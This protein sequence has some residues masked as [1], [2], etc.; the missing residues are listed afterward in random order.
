MQAIAQWGS[1][2]PHL[3]R[4]G[5]YLGVTRTQWEPPKL[6]SEKS[7]CRSQDAPAAPGQEPCPPAAQHARASPNTIFSWSSLPAGRDIRRHLT[8][9]SGPDPA[10]LH[11][12]APGPVPGT[13]E[14]FANHRGP[15]V[16]TGDLVQTLCT[17]HSVLPRASSNTRAL[18]F[19]GKRVCPAQ[20]PRTPHSIPYGVRVWL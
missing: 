17:P 8:S 12:P 15:R 20:E 9:P 5:E 4:R 2:A 16:L 14:S 3:G 13:Q 7:K 6:N 1:P 10:L 11:A 18:P 19:P